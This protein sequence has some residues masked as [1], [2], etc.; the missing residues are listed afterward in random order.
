MLVCPGQRR[1]DNMGVKTCLQFFHLSSIATGQAKNR[2]ADLLFMDV[3]FF[4]DVNV[5]TRSSQSGRISI[6]IP[7]LV[8]TELLNGS[9]RFPHVFM[10]L[11]VRRLR[12]Q[13]WGFNGIYISSTK[14]GLLV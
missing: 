12:G 13:I 6:W 7:R 2:H 4:M 14:A 9:F 3:N 11:F 1:P 8:R 10:C 5:S